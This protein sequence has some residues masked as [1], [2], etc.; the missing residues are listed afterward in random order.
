VVLH[1]DATSLDGRVAVVT[2]GGAGIGRAIAAADAE[3][4]TRVSVWEK[5]EVTAQS[6]ADDTGVFACVADKRDAE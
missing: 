3:L 1:R 2:G 6:C 5:D 4:S